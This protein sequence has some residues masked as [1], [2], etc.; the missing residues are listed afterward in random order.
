MLYDAPSTSGSDSDDPSPHPRRGSVPRE[1]TPERR[2]ADREGATAP[3]L[4]LATP[5]E[6]TPAPVAG[7]T[8]T[9]GRAPDA[10][11]ITGVDASVTRL[12]VLDILGVLLGVLPVA[13]DD[14]ANNNTSRTGANGTHPAERFVADFRRAAMVPRFRPAPDAPRNTAGG[15]VTVRFRDA[16]D[17]ATVR[18]AMDGGWIN[19]QAVQVDFT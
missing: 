12:H 8:G 13:D 5:S 11:V 2:G 3:I 17:A 1:P 7:P 6:A 9:R 10:V 14:D 4:P 18:Q 19:G 16:K 15:A